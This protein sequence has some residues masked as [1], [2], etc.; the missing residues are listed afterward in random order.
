MGIR[1]YV[2]KAI[3]CTYSKETS[4]LCKRVLR[5]E[6]FNIKREQKPKTKPE[7]P[8][9]KYEPNQTNGSQAN[10]DVAGNRRSLQRKKGREEGDQDRRAFCISAR[11]L[12]VESVI[13]DLT[14][15]LKTQAGVTGIGGGEANILQLWS[16]MLND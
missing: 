13:A 8:K 9:N 7:E 3:N 4:R 2:R 12:R 5:A 11:S 14:F 15:P 1:Y 6:H 16:S 10:R